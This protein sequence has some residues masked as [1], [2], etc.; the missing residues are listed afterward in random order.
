[1]NNCLTLAQTTEQTNAYGAFF[2]KGEI[3]KPESRRRVSGSLPWPG[4]NCPKVLPTGLVLNN[5]KSKQ[6]SVSV[7]RL[8]DTTQMV[9]L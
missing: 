1:M 3:E 2:S 7:A 9:L 4:W 6:Y 8:G 5:A